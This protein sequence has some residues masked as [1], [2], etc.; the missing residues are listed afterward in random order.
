M[1]DTDLILFTMLAGIVVL[2]FGIV[3]IRKDVEEIKELINKKL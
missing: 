1:D 2:A 3:L